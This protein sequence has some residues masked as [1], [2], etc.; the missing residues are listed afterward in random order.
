MQLRW[1]ADFLAVR[2][3]WSVH[4]GESSGPNIQLWMS[5]AHRCVSQGGVDE[6][7][8]EEVEVRVGRLGLKLSEHRAARKQVGPWKPGTGRDGVGKEVCGNQGSALSQN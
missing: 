3:L 4:S 5:S 7:D 6:R 1:Q 2:G 8:R